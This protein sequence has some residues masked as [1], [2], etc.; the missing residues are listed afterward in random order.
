MVY[1]RNK[2]RHQVLPLLKSIEP[3]AAAA[4]LRSMQH[5][6][7]PAALYEQAIA[8]AMNRLNLKYSIRDE[9]C[10]FKEKPAERHKEEYT[11]LSISALEQE[12][13]AE[14]I[15]YEWLSGY[16]FDFRSVEQIWT[17]RM[18]QSGR[19]Y[20][21][22]THR[23]LLD[24]GHFLLSETTAPDPAVYELKEGVSCWTEP[25]NLKMSIL[26]AGEAF[27][28]SPS[29]ACLDADKLSFPLL[30]R[31]PMPGDSFVPLGMKGHKLLSDYFCD[32]KKNIFQKESS[33]L[34]L[35]GRDIVW[36]LGERIDH[37]YRVTDST[38]H[39]CCFSL[40]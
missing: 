8:E 16:G 37:R 22:D 9:Q 7:A 25:V 20:F 4:I 38:K 30:L 31:R 14:D 17:R 21:S 3:S 26:E 11:S 1:R 29:C 15:L 35:S 10:G 23:L 32:A 13:L 12:P 28:R 36:V 6:A 39:I 2:I 33:W 34:L 5:L 40:L 27:P 18:G 24:R 19:Q